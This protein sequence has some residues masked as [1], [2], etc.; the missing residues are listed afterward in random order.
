MA[1]VEAEGKKEACLLGEQLR[2]GTREIGEKRK[3]V[4][5]G[6][7]VSSEGWVLED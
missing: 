1:V 7:G 4:C 5:Q 6:Y 2:M 3:M